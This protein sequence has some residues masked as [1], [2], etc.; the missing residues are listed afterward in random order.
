MLLSLISVG[1][2]DIFKRKKMQRYLFESMNT[3]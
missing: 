1:L 3:S 2:E